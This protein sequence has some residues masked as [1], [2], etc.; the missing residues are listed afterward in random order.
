MFC[1]GAAQPVHRASKR[2]V[3]LASWPELAELDRLELPELELLELP[4]LLELLELLELR[5]TGYPDLTG[6]PPRMHWLS[7]SELLMKSAVVQTL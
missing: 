6:S 5:A 7:L 4:E 3:Q 2:Q 1:A